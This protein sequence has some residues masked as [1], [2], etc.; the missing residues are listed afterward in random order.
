[1]AGTPVYFNVPDQVVTVTASFTKADGVT[2]ASPVTVVCVV[3]DPDGTATTYTWSPP[4][5]G[6]NVVYQVPAMMGTFELDLQ[7]LG[8]S[9]PAGLWSYVWS[10]AGGTVAQ[11]A[12]VTAGSFRVLPLGGPAGLGTWYV[13]K[14]E[15]K[16]RL[17]IA[18]S[19]TADDYEL[20]LAVQG[21]SDW[22]SQYCGQVFHQL[23]EARTYAPR[24]VWEMPVDPFVPGSI[25]SFLLDYTGDGTF[26]TSWTEG[27]NYQAL[28]QGESYNPSA[29][30]TPRP[31][32]YIRVL[33]GGPATVAGGQFL[34]FTWP[35]TH[36]DR[37]RITATWGWQEVPA[38]VQQAALMMAA[39]LFKT[40]DAPW[41]I[42]GMGELGLVKAQANPWIVELLRPYVNPNRKVGI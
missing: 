21:V 39:D 11:G 9:A 20:Q 33:L 35:F 25:T 24:S 28:R 5:T 38:G 36:Q 22:I 3:T 10:G 2:A 26:D 6:T 14:E 29:F 23:T 8:G 1:M 27:V 41:G 37:I 18:Q 16:S 4:A 17:G 15:V 19:N 32:N 7:V 42:A 13:S 12:Q 34:P 30:G 31:H 40:K